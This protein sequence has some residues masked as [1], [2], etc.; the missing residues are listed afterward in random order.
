MNQIGFR[1]PHSSPHQIQQEIHLCGRI[2]SPMGRLHPPRGANTTSTRLCQNLDHQPRRRSP[3]TPH[4]GCHGN[5]KTRILGTPPAR[6]QVQGAIFTLATWA[7]THS[8]HPGRRS[9]LDA[10]LLHEIARTPT[11]PPTH[12]EPLG[13]TPTTCSPTVHTPSRTKRRSPTPFP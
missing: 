2:P 6:Y 3:Y 1:T 12:I 9:S 4:T 5:Q 7:D 8:H 13:P 10:F 11:P